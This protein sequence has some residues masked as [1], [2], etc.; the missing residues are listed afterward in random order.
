M[1]KAEKQKFD[2]VLVHRHDIDEKL[3]DADDRAHTRRLIKLCDAIEQLL[4]RE[5]VGTAVGALVNALT[6]LILMTSRSPDE[7][8]EKVFYVRDN[9]LAGIVGNVKAMEDD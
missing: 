4:N 3:D 1:T 2:T 5:E 6:K 8:E 7:V 9:L